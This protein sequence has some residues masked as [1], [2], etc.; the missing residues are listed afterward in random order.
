MVLPVWQL[1]LRELIGGII[2]LDVQQI[3]AILH[4]FKKYGNQ[5][6]SVIL[7]AGLTLANDQQI[8][9]AYVFYAQRFYSLVRISPIYDVGLIVGT[10]YSLEKSQMSYNSKHPSFFDIRTQIICIAESQSLWYISL[11]ISL[12]IMDL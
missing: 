5:R 7:S 6:K 12:I 1:V 11:E 2:S 9:Q 4:N 10:L 8:F 3:Q